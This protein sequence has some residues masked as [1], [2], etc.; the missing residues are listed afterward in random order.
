MSNLFLLQFECCMCVKGWLCVCTIV[1]L[2]SLHS[3][4]CILG[5]P[6]ADMTPLYIAYGHRTVHYIFIRRL[7][8]FIRYRLL[9][10][11]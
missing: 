2:Y 7:D 1:L 6:F 10:V 4:A 5:V 11:S 3:S 9:F 8:V